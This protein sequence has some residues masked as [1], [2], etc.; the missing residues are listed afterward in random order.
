MIFLIS[1]NAHIVFFRHVPSIIQFLEIY[2]VGTQM[3]L[4]GLIILLMNYH[5]VSL[6]IKSMVT[7]C[8][9]NFALLRTVCGFEMFIQQ[10]FWSPFFGTLFALKWS[11]VE[12]NC[13]SVFLYTLLGLK[14]FFTIVTWVS[15]LP[16]NMIWQGRKLLWYTNLKKSVFELSYTV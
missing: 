10:I 2:L 5:H 16:A 13:I 11:L 12:M 9:T 7:H 8:S 15:I 3:T 4:E 6:Q 1:I 14:C